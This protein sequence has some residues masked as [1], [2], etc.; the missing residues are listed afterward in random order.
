MILRNIKLPLEWKKIKCLYKTAFPKYERKPLGLIWI[1]TCQKKADIW[2]IESEGEFSGFAI[3]MNEIDM[4]LLDYFAV[5]DEKRGAGLGTQA[6]RKLQEYYAGKRFFLEI[7]SVYVSAKNLPERCCRKQFYCS[8]GMREMGVRVNVFGTEMEL[9]GH[10]CRVS[11]EEYNLLYRMSY[12]KWAAGNI[13]KVES[14]AIEFL[15]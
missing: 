2:I 7:E 8:N 5:S 14:N 3:T 9:L 13:K 12:G 4:V 15:N 1:K 6:L 11:F 10:N